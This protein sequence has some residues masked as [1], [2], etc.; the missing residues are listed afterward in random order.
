MIIAVNAPDAP[1]LLGL[2]RNA[3]SLTRR[4]FCLGLAQ[5]SILTAADAIAAAKGEWPT[6]MSAFLGFLDSN[7]AL[8]AQIEWA[9]TGSIERMHPF[10]L[11]L[12]S[13][14]TL[15]DAEVDALFGLV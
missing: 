12:A 9:A 4:Q 13:W 5:A 11:S 10:V 2:K 7:Q 3:A 8:D 14:L 15:T 1:A 6:A